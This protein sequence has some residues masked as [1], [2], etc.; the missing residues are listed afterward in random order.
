M[1]RL[2][3][4]YIAMLWCIS[5]I[6]AQEV[7][8]NYVLNSATNG[9]KTYVARDYVTLKPGFSYKAVS[10]QKFIA[11]IDQALLFPPDD[12]TY[13]TDDDKVTDDAT[14]GGVVG[15]I[16]GQFNVSSSGAATYNIP[17]EC[18]P[19]INGMQPNV[20]LNYNS[21]SGNG[22]AGWGWNIN[23]VSM[24]GRVPKTVYHNGKIEGVK[25]TN[26]DE[27][28]LDGVRLIKT[29][30]ISSDKYEYRK[31]ADDQS[32]IIA[33]GI[34]SQGPTYFE[35]ITKNGLKMRYDAVFIVQ[36]TIVQEDRITERYVIGFDDDDEL[37][38][39]SIERDSR[40]SDGI[41]PVGV[42]KWFFLKEERIS[43]TST[44][45]NKNWMLTKVTD[46]NGN[47][48]NYSYS[49]T[50]GKSST[51]ETQSLYTYT[52]DDPNRERTYVRTRTTTNGVTSNDRLAS[53]T[54]G[55]E[56]EEFGK[57]QLNYST[58]R[59]ENIITYDAG[60]QQKFTYRL[61]D[62]QVYSAGT[63]LKEYTIAHKSQTDYVESI[64]LRG[65]NS[66]SFNPLTFLWGSNSQSISHKELSIPDDGYTGS[67][68][69]NK[70][71]VSR[72]INGDG[73]SDLIA[74]FIWEES[75]GST[76][77]THQVFQTFI[78]NNHNG[79]VS[80]SRGFS[81][82]DNSIRNQ[83]IFKYS[84]KLGG[85]ESCHVYDLSTRSLIVPHSTSAIFKFRDVTKQKT[86]TW[87]ELKTHTNDTPLNAIR[88]FNNDGYDDMLVIEQH[89]K[90]GQYP[91][92]IIY[93][94]P[95]ST[96]RTYVQIDVNFSFNAAPKKLF[97]EDYNA[98]GLKDILVVTDSGYHLLKNNGG[99]L[100]SSNYTPVSFSQLTSPTG[101]NATYSCIESGDFNGDGLPDFVL[102]EHCNSN[103]YFAINNGDGYFTKSALTSVNAVEESYTGKNNSK[104]QCLVMDFNND[105]KSDIV[106]I[107][108]AYTKH[109][110][111]W[112]EETYGKFSSS[113]VAWYKSTGTN[114]S[115][116]KKLNTN[117]EDYSYKHL[118]CTGDYN[119]D[120]RMDLLSYSA[121]LYSTTDKD[122]M[123]HL[124]YSNN[125]SFNARLLSSVT[126][127]LK[128]KTE[129]KYSPLTNSDVYNAGGVS[130]GNIVSITAPIYVVKETAVPDG[131]GG[132][133]S[134]SYK[135]ESALVHPGGRGYLGFMAYNIK[136]NSTGIEVESRNVLNTTY[137]ILLPDKTT[138][139][140]G[141]NIISI[142]SQ[143]IALINKG[144]KRYISQ[145][146][147]QKAEDKLS[148]IAKKTD[149][150]TYDAYGNPTK[151]STTFDG[152][153]VKEEQSISYVSNGSW[154]P[155][156]PSKVTV[157]KSNG[158][159]SQDRTV[160][161]LYDEKGNLAKETRDPGKVNQLVTE[162][163]EPDNY[164]NPQKIIVTANGKSRGTSI[165][166]STSGRF[167]IEKTN[168]FTG[169]KTSYSYNETTGLLE[170][171]KQVHL[172]LTSRFEYDG[173]GRLK[174]TTHPN[175]TYS[176][177]ALQW[178]NGK[179]PSK[180]KYYS[181]TET[182]GQSPVWTW[183]DAQGRELRQEYYGFDSNKKIS[184]D[185]EYNSI[186]QLTKVSQPYFS[187][188]T[189]SNEAEY[190]YDD[191]GRV[192]A[193]KT[194]MGTTTTSYNQLE[195]TVTSPNGTQKE[196]LNKAGQ[197][198]SSS[199]NGR[200][201]TYTYWPSG[202][203]KTATPQGGKAVE[204]TF[205]L[206][207]NRIKLLDPDA[208]T[209]TSAYNGFGEVEWEEHKK[210]KADGSI[211]TIRTSYNY[212]N[213]GR[214]LT[215]TINGKATS[216]TYNDKTGF[217]ERVEQDG[218]E[219]YYKYDE[220]HSTKLGRVTTYTE[221]IGDKTFVTKSAYDTYGREVKHTYPSGYYTTSRYSK[222][223]HLAEIK[224]KGSVSVWKAEETNERGQLTSI[225]KG[226]RTSTYGFDSRG[227]PESITSTGIIE[228]RYQFNT[229]GNLEYREDKLTNQKEVFSYHDDNQ[230]K[231]WEL[232]KNSSSVGTF[233]MDYDQHGNITGKSDIGFSMN[234]TDPQRI[235]A[236]TSISGNPSL[237]VDEEQNITYTDF[238]K[239]KTIS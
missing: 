127:G 104:D 111:T 219:V 37:T 28:A 136:N 215:S 77:S 95:S 208:G 188:D 139:K 36:N 100:N 2:I 38:P 5:H 60:S 146:K 54:Y 192:S 79:T 237:I 1:K 106:I 226:S 183:S 13:L 158:S 75:I 98:D 131:I 94:T 128:N 118:I 85:I 24:I 78:A 168:D 55:N 228:Q 143:D 172:G 112:F 9:N 113:Y 201:V 108:S 207:G 130:E 162:Y 238:R 26:A 180:A 11:K 6:I 48:I 137:T 25:W 216:H 124:H 153:N 20:S 74:M 197:L 229:K 147:W 173:F 31:E 33:Y 47:Y 204:T 176:V 235:H 189:K 63:K 107:E 236:L 151:I 65:Q 21:Q 67:E 232:F 97:V 43:K 191:Y 88:D 218:H 73:L 200:T 35:V 92:K 19:G 174:K 170:S 115:L 198:V 123:F 195:T 93:N 129:I 64:T 41:A 4:I 193:Q 96:G 58:S 117:T 87:F 101:F 185:S 23:G 83:D 89:A 154:C 144:G 203:T 209:I 140:K 27:L 14:K 213:T 109:G 175:G 167:I 30:T 149:Y 141:S 134:T 194:P 184:I 135:Y 103:W 76:V 206:Q 39:I 181:Y 81:C 132:K 49:K 17:V 16:P 119:G 44:D 110:G 82:I 225:K 234:Y 56:D 165:K 159:E 114:V 42:G 223:G 211:E 171:E 202:L 133:N 199:V 22:I 125:S 150:N 70:V 161:Y 91:G 18:P 231:G 120:G 80:F 182:S 68:T 164:G 220:G 217:L 62:I 84:G 239:V 190:T 224:S 214:V 163:K 7:K 230:L 40:E 3:T 46:T 145:L 178:A 222:Y 34:N 71:W 122:K 196:T 166:Y 210:T 45:I 156:K 142:N 126:D 61:K 99:K 169:F 15:S 59:S 138:T 212:D 155:N 72:D 105:G 205:N 102:N 121:N 160:Q 90:N 10:G 148:G 69:Q 227:L 51:K 8:T 233:N 12:A 50:S 53:I 187:G 86:L 52:G 179:G 57:I 29:K 177:Y 32:K 186:G 157:K 66:V 221:K 152:S 116:V